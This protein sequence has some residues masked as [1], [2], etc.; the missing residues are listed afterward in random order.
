MKGSLPRAILLDFYG[1]VVE[2]DDVPIGEICGRISAVSPLKVTAAEVGFYWSHIFSQLCSQSFGATFQPQKD[3]ELLS[4]RH[5]LQHYE[6][7][8]D[9]LVLSQVL[10]E[11]WAHP[12]IFPE[13]KDILAQCEIP[14]CVVSNIDN[15]ELQ[16]ALEHN[17]LHFDYI[18]TSED[19]KAYKPRR[20]VFEKALSLVGLSG[21]EVLYVGDSF[22]SDVRGAKGQGMP[23]LWINRKEKAVPSIDVSADYVSADLTGLLTIL[24]REKGG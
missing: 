15:V 8:L 3:L 14:M 12:A 18:V 17:S 4:L 20:E 1:T 5:V 21:T 10:Y 7:N 19:C 11:Y 2:E 9:A 16:S 22:N 6:A 24:E 23:V 13:S